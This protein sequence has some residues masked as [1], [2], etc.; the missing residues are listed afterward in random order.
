MKLERISLEI[1]KFNNEKNNANLTV[2]LTGAFLS[3][4]KN[5]EGLPGLRN[6]RSRLKKIKK[7]K[8]II[9]P[10]SNVSD[11]NE[12]QKKELRQSIL[13]ERINK[14]LKNDFKSSMDVEH[15]EKK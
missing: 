2:N 11:L 13:K 12:I 6:K 3:K 14:V 9:N 8:V 4:I 15:L 1:S 10:Q 7:S 5:F